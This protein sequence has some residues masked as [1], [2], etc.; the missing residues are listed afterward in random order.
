MT[1]QQAI[2]R[3][4]NALQRNEA[5]RALFLTG[6]YGVGLEDAHSDLDF[7]AVVRD[8]DLDAFS[9]LWRTAVEETG[10]IV[11]WRDHQLGTGLINA[12]TQHWLRIDVV[13]LPPDRL[14]AYSRDQLRR[15][16]DRD[17]IAAGLAEA[18]KPTSADPARLAYEI[19]EFIRILGLLPVVIGRG[20]L[21]NAVT[22]LTLLRRLLIELLILET[23]AP[24][25]GGALHLNRLITPE[26]NALLQTLPPLLLTREAV[27]EAHLR[28]A[29]AYLPR[30]RRLAERHGAPWPEAFE[31]ATWRHLAQTL[32]LELEDEPALA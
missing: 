4:T 15:L 25:R 19:E 32:G 13:A 24:N 11:L 20:E 5:V 8:E 2:E 26:Q 17:D 3:I 29:A 22:G 30:A 16:F 10:P 12:I 28:Y 6:S 7:L 23:G 9:R 14:A 1:P 31:T 18:T 27:I 21:V